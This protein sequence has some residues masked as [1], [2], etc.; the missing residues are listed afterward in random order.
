MSLVG[1]RPIIPPQ[2]PDLGDVYPLYISVRPGLTGLWQVSG[3]NETS[4]EQRIVWDRWY[5]QNWSI[6]H[7]IVILFKTVRVFLTGSGAY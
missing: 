6:W 1:P 4:F 7:D 2:I 3:R 5:V